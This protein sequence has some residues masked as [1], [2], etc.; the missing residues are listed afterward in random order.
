MLAVPTGFG[1]SQGAEIVID[2]DCRTSGDL[3]RAILDGEGT[4]AHGIRTFKAT[5][6]RFKNLEIRNF[7]STGIVLSDFMDTDVT[8]SR[9]ITVEGS[10]YIHDIGSTGISSVGSDNTILAAELDNIGNDGITS[11]GRNVKFIG[12]RIRRVSYAGYTGDCIQLSGD[13]D[14]TEVQNV[15]CD[16]SNIDAKQCVVASNVVGAANFRIDGLECF[17]TPGGINSI[18][19]YLEGHATI[20]HSYI[21]GAAKFGINIAARDSTSAYVL[22]NVIHQSGISCIEGSR[23]GARRTVCGTYCRNWQHMYG[24]LRI[25]N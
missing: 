10:I 1:G 2:G 23:G 9:R 13:I 14:G 3:P 4:V 11:S 22:D 7:S 17:F 8:L 19:V 16:H 18:G 15:Y 6:I 5:D 20:Q 25:W 12:T 21:Y 24:S